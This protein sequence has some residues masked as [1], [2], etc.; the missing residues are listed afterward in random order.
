MKEMNGNKE[1]EKADYE[2]KI[3]DYFLELYRQ[4]GYDERSL[5]WTK[6]KQYIRF[7]QLLKNFRLHSASV[8]DVGCGFGDMLTFLKQRFRENISYFGVDC[9]PEYVSVAKEQ[10]PEEQ[11]QF[12]CADF[13]KSSLWDGRTF[14]YIVASGIFGYRCWETDEQQYQYVDSVIGRALE[15]CNKGISLDFLSDK[16]DYRTSGTDFHASPERILQIAY[17]YSRNVVLDNSALP[18]EFCITIMKDDSFAKEKTVFNQY[19]QN[20]VD[21][22]N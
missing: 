4:Y 22:M 2:T 13:M 9:I 17:K 21:E 16:T 6:H 10:H 19:L 11:D 15:L 3:K 5:G 1:M 12:L 14:D 8:L 20:I 18:F 7:A